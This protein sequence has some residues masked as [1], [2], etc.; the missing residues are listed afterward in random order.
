MKSSFA[1]NDNLTDLLKKKKF[2]RNHI[3]LLH[4]LSNINQTAKLKFIESMF[5]FTFNSLFYS[6]ADNSNSRFLDN[7]YI[8]IP[9][10]KF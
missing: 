7:I 5:F 2:F 3:Y 1:K 8:Y 10:F 4:I 6:K 9:H